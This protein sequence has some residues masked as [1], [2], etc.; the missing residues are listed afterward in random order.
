MLQANPSDIKIRNELVKRNM[1]LVYLVA[2]K[3]F[4]KFFVGNDPDD[5]VS[6]GVI[7][8][9][10]GIKSF[11]P[12][13]GVQFSTY[14]YRAIWTHISRGID[15]RNQISFRQKNA[16]LE[17]KISAFSQFGK[18][19][20]DFLQS[21]RDNR[22]YDPSKNLVREEVRAKINQLPAKLAA[23]I[24]GRFFDNKTL[25]AVG[26][27]IG[28]TKERVRQLEAKALDLLKKNFNGEAA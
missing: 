8:L 24:R 27:D 13:L 26:H 15:V 17:T 7:G 11:N 23:V 18:E 4:G 9:M 3:Y 25:E 2:K 5:I 20:S 12:E 21:V 6:D 10:A 19:D 14:A 28:V 1:G 22:E 16:G